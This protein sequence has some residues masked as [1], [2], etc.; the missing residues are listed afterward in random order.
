MSP[1]PLPR[2]V[3]IGADAHT[4]LIAQLRE[5]RPDLDVRGNAPTDITEA[6][7][8]WGDTYIGFKR[9]PLPT[10][11]NI[12]WVHC[13]GA[14]VD[15]WLYP[16]ELP[17]SILLTRTSESFGTYIAEWAL[18][19]ALAFTQQIFDLNDC[20][21]RHEW[22]PR[23]VRYIRGSRALI[24]GTGEIGSRIG[25]LF[26]ALGCSVRGVSRSGQGD[27]DIFTSTVSVD[28]LGE[29]VADADWLIVTIPLTTET[30]GL[31]GRDVMSACH[32]AFMI[33]AGRGAVV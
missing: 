31:I 25:R 20:Q 6:D 7:F 22:R 32:G 16:T 17:R 2:R 23:E 1:L 28:R 9:P 27:P 11:G 14:G 13:T 33:K 5:V 8:S 4:E 3:V 24:V 12:R 19:R 10:M 15:A 26:S 18:A 21:Q 30:R 29:S